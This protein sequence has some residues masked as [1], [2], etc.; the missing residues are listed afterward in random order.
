[1]KV[2]LAAFK[3]QWQGK[4]VLAVTL[5]SS[6][7]VVDAM[8]LEDG[9]SRVVQS[10][11]L[12]YGAE[13][14]LSNA[15][16]AGQEIAAQLAVAGVR[17]KRCVVCVPPGWA[18]TTSTD[19]PEISGEDLRGYLELRA[20]QEFPIA[21]GELRLAHCAYTLPDGKQRATLVAVSA[22]R[23][24][25]LER[26]FQ[27]AGCRIVSISLGLDACLPQDG[28]PAALHFLA[29]GTHVDLVI[30]AGGG[31][32][33][34]RSIEGTAAPSEV[35]FDTARFSREVRIT[36]G[37]LPDAVRQQL[38]EARFSGAPEAAESLCLE[39][40]QPLHRLGI[41]SRI[42]RTGGEANSI[43]TARAAA[44]QHL[45][46]Q[47]VVFEFVTPEVN[48]WQ[49]MLSRFESRQR[50]WAVA[51]GVALVLLP[52]IVFFI[53]SRIESGLQGEWKRMRGTVAELEALQ[54]GIR[55][56]RPWFDSTP[57]NIQLFDSL[58]EAFPEQG[59]VWAKTVEVD[60][61]HKV[62][63]AA[64][65]RSE[66]ALTNFLDRLRARPGVVGLQRLQSRGEN[67]I[68][69]SFTYRWEARDGR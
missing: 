4:S 47:P 55:K 46:Q 17:E 7:L 21:V 32:A 28:T 43:G 57:T 8:R 53:R 41:E 66:A 19:V 39:I 54:Q 45:R 25:A 64:F 56:F 63:G 38:R 52:L 35:A 14:V 37:G 40:R 62:T 49:T 36:L 24:A 50:R 5:E 12:P 33:A 3:K 22:K 13:A 31:I 44:E 65:A 20:E 60:A 18:L 58:V 68:Q 61:D 34:L 10:F 23:L 15:E 51:A 9:E 2:D 69:F 59:E 27:A 30:A 42:D 6:R 1:M 11:V 48:R 16:K 26:M 67:P 29:N